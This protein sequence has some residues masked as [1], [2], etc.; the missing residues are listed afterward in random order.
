MQIHLV[1]LAD[2]IIGIKKLFE[3]SYSVCKSKCTH[4]DYRAT[5]YDFNLPAK[6][7]T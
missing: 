4:K 6:Q 7:C 1:K 5:F 2:T 3:R